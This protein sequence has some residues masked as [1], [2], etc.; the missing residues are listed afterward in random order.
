MKYADIAMYEAKKLG[1]NQYHFYTEKLNETVQKAILLDRNMRLALKNNEYQLYY[2]PKVDIKSSKITSVEALIRWVSPKEGIINPSTF[3]PLAEENNFIQELGEWI[4]NDVLK[5]Y[6][7]WRENGIDIAIS[8]NI[9]A[10]Q[11]V[12]SD[13]AN[14]MISNLKMLR[15]PASKIDLEITEYIFMQDSRVTKVNLNKLHDYGIS[16]SMDDFGTGYSSL[17]Y[18]K[19]FPINYLK[20]DKSFIDDFNTKEGSVFVETI[21]KLGQTLNIKIIAE[22]IEKIEQLEY[23]DQ[24]KCDEYQGF[25]CS[26][27]LSAKDLEE[28]Y[29][30]REK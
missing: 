13:F 30:N 28:F 16:I 7:L 11:L 23:L 18:L 9:C 27:P 22:G 19:K 29:L 24:I 17:S 5:Q 4:I 10:K 20:I 3:I 8:I 25:Y 15:I 26:K 21:V 12:I 6:V 1:R 2:Q 14:N